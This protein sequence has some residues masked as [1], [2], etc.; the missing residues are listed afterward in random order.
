MNN[1]LNV[2]LADARSP[3]PP[4]PIKFALVKASAN[5]GHLAGEARAMPSPCPTVRD[6]EIQCGLALDTIKH[7]RDV[8]KTIVED[9]GQHSHEMYPRD[10]VDY[11]NNL[12]LDTKA[13][14]D[15]AIARLQEENEQARAAAEKPN[16]GNA[17]CGRRTWA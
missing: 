11:L 9:A 3:T 6:F 16:A 1:L 17:F 15:A 8:L 12:A 2:M 5:I 13:Q 4:D 14:F 7:F 10:L